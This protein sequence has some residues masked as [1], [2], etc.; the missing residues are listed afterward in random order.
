M[1]YQNIFKRHEIK[2]LLNRQEKERMLEAMKGYMRLDAYGHACIRNI[3]FD[4]DTYRLIR[5]SIEKPVY[6]EKLRVR[7]YRAAGPDDAV[8]VELKK[9]YQSVVYKR[10][11]AMTEQEARECFETG[12]PLPVRSQIADEIDYFRSYYGPLRPAVFLSYEREAYEP[13]DGS[14]FRVTFDEN[15]R[16]RQDELFLGAGLHGKPLLG[17][18][19]ALMELKAADAI[20]LWMSRQLAS[21]RIYQVSFSKYGAAYQQILA[22]GTRQKIRNTLPDGDAFTTI[23]E[24]GGLRYA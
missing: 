6:K 15:I 20:P 21:Q 9:K 14:G 4:T 3:Y 10:R 5:R 1:D 13:L 23:L 7:S 8:F 24:N 17:E 16:Y 18:G 11:I 22:E 12:A 2:Y 19:E